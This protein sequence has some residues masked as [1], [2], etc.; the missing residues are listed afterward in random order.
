MQV[1]NKEEGEV[2]L[3]KRILCGVLLIKKL[4]RITICKRK[5]RCEKGFLLLYRI[6]SCV[7]H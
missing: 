2:G 7:Y 1:F 6:F 3:M 4:R 5:E